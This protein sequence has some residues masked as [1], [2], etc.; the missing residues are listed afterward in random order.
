MKIKYSN[1]DT[2]TIELEKNKIVISPKAMELLSVKY[3]DRVSINYLQQN[4]GKT[5]PVISK[6]GSFVDKEVGSKLTKQNTFSFKG[7]QNKTLSQYGD[8][9]KLK[10]H[11]PGM[12]RMTPIS[13]F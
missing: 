5:I 13:Y 3:G 9:F 4:N 11:I 7:A 1:I 10:E 2:P 12:Y 6:S 8:F